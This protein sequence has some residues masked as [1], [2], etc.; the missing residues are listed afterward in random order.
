MKLEFK[1]ELD[2]A[3]RGCQPPLGYLEL[4][5]GLQDLRH[6]DPLKALWA[7]AGRVREDAALTELVAETPAE[8][9]HETLASAPQAWVGEAIAGFLRDYRHH[10]VAEL[11][12][13]QPRW[14]EDPTFV[15]RTLKAYVA[16]HDPGRDPS[17]MSQKQHAL[18]LAERARAQ[19][20]FD[21][22]LFGLGRG[23][24][25]GKLDLLRRYSWWREEMRDRSSR[26]YALIRRE[27]LALAA[28]LAQ[29]GKLAAS[30]DVWQLTWRETLDLACGQLG[31]EAA[32]A[33]V[34][35]R[36]EDGDGWRGFTNPNELGQRFKQGGTAPA[37]APPG[38]L[39]G[40]P[41]S[42]GLVTA[43]ARIVPTI[44][45]AERLGAG[46]ILVT[47]FTDPGWT[48]LFSGIAGVVTET[49]GI[50][51]H[52]A[53]IAREYGIPAVLAV[54]GATQRIADGQRVVLD[55]SAGTIV[56]VGE[57]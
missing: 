42:P 26:C 7:L 15:M 14:D 45:D 37:Q 24:F 19:A 43:I 29:E 10:S 53:V 5:S 56:P 30:E 11:D 28:V 21:G 40:I 39:A 38:G 35:A 1:V 25:F 55:G 17:A 20:Y 46:E 54:A 9:L 48:P 47:K 4:L 23:A 57:P 31:G 49:G 16:Q 12:I 51:S 50:L 8:A 33:L 6:L 27:T 44:H 52:A 34:A 32:R 41:C 2:K 22:K 3:N 36:R 13:T 18:Y